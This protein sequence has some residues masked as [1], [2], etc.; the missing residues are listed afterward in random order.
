MRFTRRRA[1][2]R[3][4]QE[5]RLRPQM[6]TWIGGARASETV[7]LSGEDASVGA[8]ME[9]MLRLVVGDKN[10]KV[11]AARMRGDFEKCM[12]LEMTRADKAGDFTEECWE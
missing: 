11:T 12:L 4:V 7:W 1:Q 3:S 8:N 10:M 6:G 9:G 2:V 5:P